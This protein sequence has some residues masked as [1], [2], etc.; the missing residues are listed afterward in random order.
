M[1]KEISL[2]ESI[3]LEQLEA[4]AASLYPVIKEF[5][6]TEQG[7]Q[8]FDDYIRNKKSSEAA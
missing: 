8:V 6:K 1:S 2:K 4:L 3:P 5:Y 7:K